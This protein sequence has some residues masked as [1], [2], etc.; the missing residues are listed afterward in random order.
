MRHSTR[1]VRLARLGLC[2]MLLALTFVLPKPATAGVITFEDLKTDDFSGI[3]VGNHYTGLDFSNALAVTSGYVLNEISFPP[4]PGVVGVMDYGGPLGISLTKQ[5]T[6]VSAYFTYN[7]RLTFSA[8]DSAGNLLAAVVS[9]FSIN[10]NDIDGES[11]SKPNELLE[12]S[13]TAPIARLLIVGSDTGGSFL[14][15]DLTLERGPVTVPDSPLSNTFVVV[16]VGLA[17]GLLRAFSRQV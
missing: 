7:S 3:S 15:D 8:F 6:R 12:L 2:S 4:R 11:G 16:S 1:H 14:M 10:T 5:F 13:T 17:F 9:A